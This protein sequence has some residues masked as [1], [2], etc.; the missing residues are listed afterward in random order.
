MNIE[1]STTLVTSVPALLAGILILVPP[2]ILN[3]FASVYLNVVGL[4]PPVRFEAAQS[5]VGTPAWP[6][7]CNHAAWRGKHMSNRMILRRTLA[8]IL[9]SAMMGGAGIGFAFDMGN[10]MNPSRWM[11][12]NSGPG[13][14]GGPMG[15]MMNP[16]RWMGGNSGP[17]GYGGGPGG[18]GGG[19]GDFGGGPGGYGGGPGGYGGGPGG[20]Y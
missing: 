4:E 3:Y 8:L 13:G 12:G 17:G 7:T 1:L 5:P 16:S 18:Y 2:G 14:S 15:N 6:G 9:G 19:P 10:M 11:G 20:G